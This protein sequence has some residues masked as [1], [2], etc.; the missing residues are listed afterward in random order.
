[1]MEIG[2]RVEVEDVRRYEAIHNGTPRDG[3]DEEVVEQD[4]DITM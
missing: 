1:M 2:V 4:V 3:R